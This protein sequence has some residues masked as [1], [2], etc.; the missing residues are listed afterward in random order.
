[1]ESYEGATIVYGQGNY[2]FAKDYVN[3][4]LYSGLLVSLDL[5]AGNKIEFIPVHREDKGIRLAE[6]EKGKEILDAFAKR[7]EEIKKEGFIE[8]RYDEF[9]R[10]MNIMYMSKLSGRRGYMTKLDNLLF[11]DF[12]IKRRYSGIHKLMLKNY[13]QCEAHRELVYSRAGEK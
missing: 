10:E 11:N 12:F 9:A 2:I 3:E 13:M 7:S 1:M 8:E 5:S 4:Y 6:G